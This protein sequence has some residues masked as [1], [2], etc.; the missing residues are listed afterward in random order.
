MGNKGWIGITFMCLLTTACPQST[1]Q[2]TAD[3]LEVILI[4]LA[5]A[6]IAGLSIAAIEYLPEAPSRR[7]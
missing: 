4:F 3:P 1:A 5:M 7:E 2:E 6:A